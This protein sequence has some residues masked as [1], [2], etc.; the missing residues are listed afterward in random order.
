MEREGES[1]NNNLELIVPH[2]KILFTT[3]YAGHAALYREN[4]AFLASFALKILQCQLK[5]TS[6]GL[7]V[8]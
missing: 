2:Y 6:T 7:Y 5:G 1:K 8:T 3:E 4:E